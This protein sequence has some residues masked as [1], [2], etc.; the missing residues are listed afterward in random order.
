MNIGWG[1]TKSTPHQ[2]EEVGGTG[3]ITL[4]TMAVYTCGMLISPLGM[5]ADIAVSSAET[6]GRIGHGGM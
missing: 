3:L 4:H 2:R 5:L 6:R 1:C